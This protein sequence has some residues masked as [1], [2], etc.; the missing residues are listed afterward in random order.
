MLTL[1]LIVTIS[2]P[3]LSVVEEAYRDYLGYKV[4]ERGTVSK[5]LAGVWGAPA[6]AGRAYLLMQPESGEKVYLRFV[7]SDPTEG[8]APMRTFGWNA[9][10]IMVKD[11]D[12]LAKRLANSP[13]RIIGPP[14]NLSFNENIRAMQVVGPANEVLYLTRVP[15]GKSNY[16]LGSA[17]TYVDYVFIVVV[18]GKDMEAMR[19]FYAG[20]MKLPVTKPHEVPI[21]IL[22]D[23]QGLN[24][25]H[26]YRLAAAQLP[27]RF[28]IE[29]DEYPQSASVRPR[30]KDDLFP[31]MSFVSF[32]V[33]SIDSLDLE[34]IQPPVVIKEAPYNG[35]RV[36]LTVG[37]AGELIELIETP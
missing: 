10:E 17:R 21:S 14:K 28:L 6:A 2:A 11:P 31:G 23:A 32:A 34:L 4:V 15:P 29:I 16:N 35:R 26:R 7:Q 1:I 18:A 8:Y 20:K 27:A 13:F 12:D 5:A 33:K 25:E 22:S 30:R 9:T 37:A 3:N 24:S 36:A 19:D